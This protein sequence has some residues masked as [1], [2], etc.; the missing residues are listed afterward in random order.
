MGTPGDFAAMLE[1]Y[2]TT[3]LRPVID[4]VF[5][6]EQAGDAHIRMEAGDQFG[7]IILKM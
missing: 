7:K 3:K 5:P 1:L 4:R 6:L 2:E